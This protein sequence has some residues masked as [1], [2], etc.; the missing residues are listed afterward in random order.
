MASG[1]VSREQRTVAG[2]GDVVSALAAASRAV[3]EE[4]TLAAALTRVVEAVGVA[5]RADVVVARALDAGGGYVSARAIRSR[6]HAVAAELE[7]SRLR[8]ASLARVAEMG[9]AAELPALVRAVAA[10]IGA[11]A[12]C[13]VPARIGGRVVGSLEVLR[14]AGELDDRERLLLRVAADHVA[15]AIRALGE[16]D[17]ARDGGD[18]RV[19]ELAAEALGAATSDGGRIAPEI[20]RLATA[21]SGAAACRLWR[22]RGPDGGVELVASRGETARL[23]T[24]AAEGIARRALARARPVAVDPGPDGRASVVTLQLGQPPLAA[25][26]LLFAEPPGDDAMARLATFAVRAAHA[27]R[28]SERAATL[29]LEVERSRVLLGVVA[30]ASAQLSLSHTLETAVAQIADLLDAER[31]AVYL[32]EDGRLVPAAGR[33]LSGPH[34]VVAQRLLELA[35]GPFR[36]RGMLLVEDAAND[37]RLAGLEAE[38]A[39]AAIQAAVAAPLVVQD[40][41]TGLLAVYFPR[42]REASKNE[43]ALLGALAAQLAVSVQNARLHEQA[44]QLGA[45]LRS[46]LSAERHA[47][48]RLGALYEISRSFAQS[49]SLETTLDA[50]ARTVV[51]LLDVDAAVIRMPDARGDYLV[52]CA[53][54]VTDA[55]LEDAIRP[56]L[57]RPQAMEKLPGRRLLRTN[58]ALVLDSRAAARMDAH[59]LLVPFLET[60]STA[61]VL[62]IATPSELLGTLTLLSLD[63]DRPITGETSDI[64]LSVAA[65]AALAIDNARLYQQQKEFADTMQRSLLPRSQPELPGLELGDAYAPSSR[66][67]VGGDVYDFMTLADGRLAV[68]LGDVT[69]HG[70]EAAAD[71]AMAKF[72]FRSLAREHPEPGDFLAAANEVVCG[73]I[74]SGK[75]ITMLYLTLDPHSGEIVCAGAG[76]PDPRLVPAAGDVRPLSVRGLALGIDR[77]QTYAETRESLEPGTSVV[78]YTDGLLEARRGGDFYGHARLDRFLGERRAL[79]PPELVVAALAD[80]RSFAGGELSDD[81]AIVAIK[82]TAT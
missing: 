29:E 7:G 62:P 74:A 39:A 13:L 11:R 16:R 51:Q 21:A 25:L 18:Q 17:G 49:L 1:E 48:R 46:V 78:L 56:V 8:V 38:V 63:P 55:R 19:L 4:P 57:G 41:V 67:D 24:A 71:M 35:L 42:G 81:C 58:R 28:S 43:W 47:A 27:L 5:L 10:R 66:V 64:G 80:C 23:P 77:S 20:V 79:R 53:V 82:R 54:H 34:T 50:V 33:A 26:Q 76:H 30:Q 9:A 70:I 59:Q 75:F 69:G 36:A 3:A 72:V 68:V 31:V 45:E 22:D 2:N 60:G 52:P 37:P 6:S 14:A 61:V 15:A 65:Q 12:A 40:D 73:E 32:R 44:T